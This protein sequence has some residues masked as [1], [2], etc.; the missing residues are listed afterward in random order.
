[1]QINSVSS[2]YPVTPHKSVSPVGVQLV[3][4]KA[5]MDIQK[6][7]ITNLLEKTIKHLG[8]NFDGRG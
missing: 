6:E 7:M 4:M 5:S 2:Y 1:M 3:V 8:Q